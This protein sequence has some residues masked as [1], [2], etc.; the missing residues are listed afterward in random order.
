MSFSKEVKKEILD[1]GFNKK[2]H[3]VAFLCGLIY[4]SAEYE[5]KGD[6]VENFFISS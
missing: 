3:A 2:E 4:S 1:N 5:L 6:S